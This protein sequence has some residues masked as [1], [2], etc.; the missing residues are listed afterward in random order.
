[1]FLATGGAFGVACAL[2]PATVAS[3]T[4]PAPPLMVGLTRVGSACLRPGSA[5]GLGLPLFA[6]FG[7]LHRGP[8]LSR[9]S[10]AALRPLFALYPVGTLLTRTVAATFVSLVAA[11]VTTETLV[12]AVLAATPGA[13][14]F[15]AVAVLGPI[16]AHFAAWREAGRRLSARRSRCIALEPAKDPADDPRPRRGR[17][18]GRARGFR[19]RWLC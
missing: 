7:T 6:L 3:A 8:L 13:I 1:M 18:F 19:S 9:G 5:A 12:L 2:T 11:S 10:L 16:H 17:P 15:A 14:A 4:S